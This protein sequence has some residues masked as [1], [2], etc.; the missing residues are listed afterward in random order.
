MDDLS[1]SPPLYSELSS[2]AFEVAGDYGVE[3]ES[4]PK[5]YKAP[6]N[7]NVRILSSSKPCV[8]SADLEHSSLKVYQGFSF[9][10]RFISMKNF[11]KRQRPNKPGK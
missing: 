7:L 8:F 9:K 4:L 6:A 3:I 5:F 2:T 1:V 11:T 10:H